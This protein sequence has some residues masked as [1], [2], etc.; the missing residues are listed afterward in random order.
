MRASI[1]EAVVPLIVDVAEEVR[2]AEKE[3]AAEREAPIEEIRL[4]QREDDVLS[5]RAVLDADAEFL[6]AAGEVR[7]VHQIEIA[8]RQL[9]EADEVI[10]RAEAGA[11]VER[12]GPFLLHLNGQILAAGHAGVFRIGFDLARSSRGYRAASCVVSTRT[13]L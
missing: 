9:D 8:L 4:R 1:D 13:V 5:L 10:D 2:F 7:P 11:E 6:A 3:L 12:A